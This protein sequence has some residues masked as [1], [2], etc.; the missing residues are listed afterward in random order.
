MTSY[1]PIFSLFWMPSLD[2][3]SEKSRGMRNTLNYRETFQIIPCEPALAS[4]S[5]E[6]SFGKFSCIAPRPKH[7][8]FKYHVLD[9][10]IFPTRFFL[11]FTGNDILSTLMLS[12]VI[13]PLL[14]TAYRQSLSAY[15]STINTCIARLFGLLLLH[16]QGGMLSSDVGS[17]IEPTSGRPSLPM[18]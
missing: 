16:I 4:L 18:Y 15:S 8:I 7:H 13:R 3:Y 2:N 5:L 11:F 6:L 1:S 14:V 10:S 12:N 9:F 17:V